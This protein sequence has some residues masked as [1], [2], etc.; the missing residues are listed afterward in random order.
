[1]LY[2]F[3]SDKFDIVVQAG[4]SNAEGSGLGPQESGYRLNDRI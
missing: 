4:Q 3:S 2:D 1:M